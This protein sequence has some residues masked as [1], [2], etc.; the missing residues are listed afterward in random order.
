MFRI[1]QRCCFGIDLP[2]LLADVSGLQDAQ[3]FGVGGHDAV[4]DPV[5]NHLDEVTGAIG[6]AMQITLLRGTANFL[7]S[8]G[9]RYLVAYAGSQPGE[10]WIEVLDHCILTTNHHAVTTL[11]APN[12]AAC[13]HIDVMNSLGR[14]LLG[15]PDVI[16][17]IGI[18]AVDENVIALE[19][20]EEIGDALVHDRRWNHQP[21]RSW[22]GQFLHKVREG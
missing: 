21:D 19:M 7:A 20:G 6:A 18:A 9:A 13:A 10:D 3:A 12:P 5:M 14:K 17:V 22:L 1:T 2:L 15:A 11:Q 16:Y 8:R 4:L